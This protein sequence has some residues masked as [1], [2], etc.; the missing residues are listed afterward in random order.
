MDGSQI[1]I[2]SVPGP[3][4]RPGHLTAVESIF[5]EA[6]GRTF[7]PGPVRDA[8]RERWLGRYLLGDTDVVVLALAGAE[9]VAGYLVGALENPALQDRFADI[10]CFRTDFADLVARFPAHLHINLAPEFR[11]RGIGQLL[12][13]TFARHA[14]AAGVPG[15]HVITGQGRRNI[16]FYERCG[17]ALEGTTTWNGHGIVL[18]GRKLRAP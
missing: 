6:S 2:L 12:I 9:T 5:F 3:D 17:F 14:A 8:F 18:L 10:T 11:S 7:V 4:L 16:G 13:E 15:V 1:T